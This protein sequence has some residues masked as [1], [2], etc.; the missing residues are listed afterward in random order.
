M[1]VAA[2]LPKQGDRD[3]WQNL[4]NYRGD[5]KLLLKGEIEDGTL[6]FRS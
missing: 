3:P 1:R 6:E 5:K 2:L 4:Q